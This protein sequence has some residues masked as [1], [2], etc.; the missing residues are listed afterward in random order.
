MP[1]I[2]RVAAGLSA[3]LFCSTSFL[4]AQEKL[5]EHILQLGDGG[6]SPPARVTDFAWLEG[7]WQAEALGG[8]V[9]EIWSSPAA[10]TM[11]GMFRLV[12]DDEV[13][14]YEIFTI[15]EEGSTALL[16]LKHFNADLTGWEEKNDTVDFPLVA[17][18]EGQAFF[19][20]VTYQR[21][22][23]DELRVYLAMH[24]KDK[25]QEVVF[26]YKRVSSD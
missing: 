25:V 7:H 22:G 13:S 8:T 20:G 2:A 23:P 5:T 14:F 18:E 6:E 15:T 9:D 24:T 26:D 11:V 3:L 21:Q 17:L 19:D 12:K 1:R 10:G 4:P 16:R